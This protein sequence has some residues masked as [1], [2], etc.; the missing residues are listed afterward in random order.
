M[1]KSKIWI[2][3]GMSIFCFFYMIMVFATPSH[4]KITSWINKCDK[5]PFA[6]LYIVQCVAWALSA[7]VI[8]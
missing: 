6:L 5:E 1:F 8:Y 7:F 4:V 3:L 2:C